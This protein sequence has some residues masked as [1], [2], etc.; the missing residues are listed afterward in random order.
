MIDA[1]GRMPDSVIRSELVSP[2][3]W[4]AKR[5]PLRVGS[6]SIC[7][8]FGFPKSVPATRSS[9]A[10]RTPSWPRQWRQPRG[11]S[12][13]CSGTACEENESSH[14]SA[15]AGRPRPTPYVSRQIR[16]PFLSSVIDSIGAVPITRPSTARLSAYSPRRPIAVPFTA[17][18]RMMRSP[19]VAYVRRPFSASNTASRDFSDASTA[20]RPPRCAAAGTF[21]AER[22]GC[23]RWSSDAATTPTWWPCDR[24]CRT[25]A[26]KVP[27]IDMTSIS[28][29]SRG[30][31]CR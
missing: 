29:S 3:V 23:D 10:P 14:S 27:R 4:V 18:S 12:P 13:G 21:G 25:N 15:S 11:A 26:S 1:L 7:W 5:A 22:P 28:G 30:S 9:T 16:S 19:V 6:N 8:V 2:R 20:P 31:D 24:Y 17:T